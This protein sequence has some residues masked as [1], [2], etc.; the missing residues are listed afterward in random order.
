MVAAYHPS[1]PH[2]LV[3]RML[4]FLGAANRRAAQQLTP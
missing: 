4:Q 3:T 2:A 1:I